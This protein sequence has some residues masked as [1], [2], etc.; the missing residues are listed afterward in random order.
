[1]EFVLPSLLV[2]LAGAFIVFSLLPKAT[3][4]L[5]TFLSIIVLLLTLKHHYDLFEGEYK[6]LTMIDSL[7][8]NAPMW[9]VTL[10]VVLV[11]GY[12]LATIGLIKFNKGS[13]IP[14]V[15]MPAM[16]ATP[17]NRPANNR[18]A[19]NRPANNRPANNRP[20]NSPAPQP[21][22]N[23]LERYVSKYV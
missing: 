9:L 23:D 17:N 22:T 16:P 15:A 20:P 5:L 3:P 4:L 7:K 19:N 11:L 2:L 12:L 13:N 1:M 6:F 21:A 18:P 14:E 8:E 10:V